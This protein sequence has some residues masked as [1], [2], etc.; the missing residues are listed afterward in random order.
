MCVWSEDLRIGLSESRK[1]KEGG[2]NYG[3][4]LLFVPPLCDCSHEYREIYLA[5]SELSLARARSNISVW[6]SCNIGSP[7]L[8]LNFKRKISP[9][10]FEGKLLHLIQANVSQQE[11]KVC[12]LKRMRGVW[13]LDRQSNAVTSTGPLEEPQN[14]T[15]LLQC[16]TCINSTICTNSLMFSL[17]N[18]SQTSFAALCVQL[19]TAVNHKTYGAPICVTG[20][21]G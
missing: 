17:L 7:F 15:E 14:N 11:M 6:Q 8:I 20:L 2:Q 9:V 18:D 4:D 21:L 16:V 13:R 3:S 19:T 12:K 1:S 5:S 10:Q